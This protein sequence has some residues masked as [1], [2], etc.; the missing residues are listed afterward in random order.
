MAT[1]SPPKGRERAIFFASTI[2]ETPSYTALSIV[3][4]CRSRIVRLSQFCRVLKWAAM[5][6]YLLLMLT[7]IWQPAPN[8]TFQL[9]LQGEIDTAWDVDMYDIDLFDT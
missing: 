7:Q 1:S 5:L 9:Q 4:T 3:A 2:I 6:I 8:T